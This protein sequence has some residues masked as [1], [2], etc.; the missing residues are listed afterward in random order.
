M[1][2][3]TILSPL[4]VVVLVLTVLGLGMELTHTAE[5]REAVEMVREDQPDDALLRDEARTNFQNAALHALANLCLTA[6][7]I[8]WLVTPDT[9]LDRLDAPSYG[10]FAALAGALVALDAS[11]WLGLTSRRRQLRVRLHELREALAE[12]KAE[13]SEPERRQR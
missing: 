5:A 8:Y 6:L 1:T 13:L 3:F 7:A 9:F 4:E 11:A 2:W 12:S 10:A